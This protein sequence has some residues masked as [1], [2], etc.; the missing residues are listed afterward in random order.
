VTELVA[1]GELFDRIVAKTHYT[2]KEA[3]D[4]VKMFLETMMYMHEA[5]VVHR[6]LKPENLLLCSETDDSDI[7]IADFGFAKKTVDLLPSETACGT[8]GYVAPEILRGI[9][10]CINV[11]VYQYIFICIYV[12]IYTYIYVYMH[13]SSSET[14]CETPGYVAPET[15]RGILISYIRMC[16]NICIYLCIWRECNY[17]YVY[18]DIYGYIFKYVYIPYV[19]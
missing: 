12:C 2:E 1:G 18:M 5:G 10:I 13:F 19:Y 16:I 17:I 9:Y 14:A 3:R 7:K 8:P 6:D 15:L 4:L 11:C